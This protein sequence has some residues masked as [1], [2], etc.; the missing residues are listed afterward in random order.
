MRTIEHQDKYRMRRLTK[1]NRN[2][3]ASFL[4]RFNCI[5]KLLGLQA[6][7]PFERLTALTRY[8]QKTVS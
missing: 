1:K 4:R 6:Q 2:T 8:Q 7:Q 3:I 5:N